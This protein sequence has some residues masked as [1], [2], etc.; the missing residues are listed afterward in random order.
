MRAGPPSL[1]P[2]RALPHLA[3]EAPPPAR[4]LTRCQDAL[5][6]EARGPGEAPPDYDLGPERRTLS[7]HAAR[8]GPGPRAPPFISPR[9]GG[10]RGLRSLAATGPAGGHGGG[11]R[12]Q[13]GAA[14]AEGAGGAAERRAAAAAGGAPLQR[15]GHL[16]VRAAAA[17]LLDLAATVGP[18]VDRPQLHH[19]PG[20][21]RQPAHH[22][23]AHLLL[24]HDHGGGTI[25]DIPFMC[26]WTFYLPVTGRY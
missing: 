2:R 12:G 20:P 1:T 22:A 26:T 14:L 23:R 24:P 10:G 15:R 16:A 19:P 21:R 4:G 9:P 18:A 11:R 8:A 17:A 7:S 3:P 25:L 6:A 13:A 5:G